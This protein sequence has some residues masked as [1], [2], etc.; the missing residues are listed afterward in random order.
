MRCHGEWRAPLLHSV[1]RQL[2]ELGAQA[3]EWTVDA[4]DTR[5]L[6]SAGALLLLKLRQHLGGAELR[7]HPEQS[8]LL[9]LLQTVEPEQAPAETPG[10]GL[11][12]H[13]GRATVT[14][15]RESAA[16]L[17][18]IGESAADS[19]PRL[20]R[21]HTLRWRQITNDIHRAGLDALPIV[22]L[23]VF[24]MGVVIAYQ[25]GGPL[26]DYGANIYLV[27]LLS[28]TMLREMAPLVTAIVVAG[29]T[30][31]AYAAQLGTMKI[32]D[33][34][35]ALR[36]LGITPTEMLVLPKF[37][38]LLIALPLLTVFADLLGLIGG[39][40]V[41]QAW[42]DIAYREFLGRLPVALDHSAYW[43]GIIKAPIFA[44]I[45]VTVGCFNGLRVNGSAEEVG[46]GTTRSVVQ[47]IFLVIV[48]DALFSV[49]FRTLGI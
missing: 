31:S 21:P 13:L 22:G 18:F 37:I 28:I 15:A 1:E 10:P 45:I 44:A 14:V 9:A 6:D 3:G 26:Q 23:L 49:L 16:L 27:D 2:G 38:A 32:T 4:R 8:R 5:A 35:D 19:L 34:V 29:R 36:S 12:E 11:L 48:T 41:A 17:Q 47:A 42:F 46:R 25:G 40:L 24:L 39:M 30:G 43:V 33:E 20:L 7:L